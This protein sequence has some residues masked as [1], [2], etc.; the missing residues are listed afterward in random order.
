MDNHPI[1]Q[2]VTNFQFRLIG[3]MTLKQFGYIVGGV[4]FAWVMLASPLFFLFKLV[5]AGGCVLGA[6]VLAFVPVE[7][8]PSDVMVLHFI[9][10]LF[11]PTQ[12][13][14]QKLPQQPSASTQKASTA[15][16]PP[17]QPQKDEQ[18]EEKV[19]IQTTPEI[20]IA[21]VQSTQQQDS[22][23]FQQPVQ[24]TQTPATLSQTQSPTASAQKEEQLENQVTQ[25]SKELEEAKEQE[26]ETTGTQAALATHQKVMGLEQTLQEL[27]QQKEDLEKRLVELQKALTQKNQQ[28]YT[29]SVVKPVQETQHVR[30][31]PKQMA[32]TTGMPLVPDV[33]NLITGVIKDS[34]GNV[35]PNILIEVKDKD[36][37]PVRAFKTN[38]LGQFAAATPLANGLYTI[39]FEDPHAKQSFDSVEITADGQVLLPLEIISIDERERLRKELFG[40]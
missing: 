24:P 35:L 23:P 31:I 1:P 19:E 21:A 33:A 37:N 7:G 6:V 17:Q 15:T 2:D 18:K 22:E 40:K 13:I 10:A 32:A 39:S 14:Y 27:T 36:G 29:P 30:K 4:I 25:L 3:D 16:P 20:A 12:F 9:K 5:L 11:N 38:Q 26:K 8:R 28:V 34:R